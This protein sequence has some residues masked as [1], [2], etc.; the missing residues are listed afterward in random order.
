MQ[1]IEQAKFRNLFLCLVLLGLSACG[2]PIY[3]F[4]GGRLGGEEAPLLELPT[5]SGV[6]QLETLPT[7]PYSVNVGFILLDGNLYLDPA[8]DREWYQ[9]ILLDSAVRIR[10]DGGDLVHPMLAVREIAPA[11]LDQFDPER[12]ILRLEPR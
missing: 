3:Y 11:V 4:A 9:N 2:E 5:T 7:D 10:F 12:I 8:E 1:K 6:I